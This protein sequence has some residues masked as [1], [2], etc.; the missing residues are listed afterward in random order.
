MGISIK[1]YPAERVQEH[2]DAIEQ[3]IQCLKTERTDL[4]KKL[5]VLSEQTLNE[6]GIKRLCKVVARNIGHLTKN[7][8]EVINKLLRLRIT[9]FSKESV[10]V[11]VALPPI[12]KTPD[13]ETE[14]S[15][16]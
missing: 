13:H 10:V 8:W 11:N 16:L 7:Q 6:E 2:I 9:V 14:L 5:E 15:H 1:N 4:K 12:L 3:K